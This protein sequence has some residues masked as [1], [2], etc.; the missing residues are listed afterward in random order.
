MDRKWRALVIVCVG[1][2]MLLLDITVVNVAL[3]DIQRELHTS[4]TD[5]Q[6]VVDAHALML[7]SCTLNAGALGDMLGRKRVFIAG[8]VLFTIAS[9]L[10]GSAGSPLFLNLPFGPVCV[11]G[12][13]V[14]LH[15]SRDEESGR[16]DPAG[17]A[18]LTA[19]LFSLVLALLRGNDWHWGSGRE[20]ALYAIAAVCLLGFVF[21]ESRKA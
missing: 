1:I 17:F 14:Y 4:F 12:A 18:L 3:P 13:L 2:F 9:A 7:A 5:L 11:A 6:W 10:C 19:G 20:I 16:F 21:A 15:E 8:V